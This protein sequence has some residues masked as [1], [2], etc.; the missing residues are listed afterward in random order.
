MIRLFDRRRGSLLAVAAIL[1]GLSCVGS[2]ARAGG[3]ADASIAGIRADVREL[4][5]ALLQV[6]SE[7]R[8]GGD[9][10]QNDKWTLRLLGLGVLVMG[11]SYPVG[12]IIWIATSTVARRGPTSAVPVAPPPVG[13]ANDFLAFRERHTCRADTVVPA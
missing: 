2:G 8:A 5:T 9:V 12:K 6:R 7:L 3:N 4:N 11:L 13:I 10:N 1:S